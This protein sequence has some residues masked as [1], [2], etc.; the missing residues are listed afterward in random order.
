MDNLLRAKPSSKVES[1][2]TFSA[3]VSGL[4]S[5]FLTTCMV[6]E[7]LLVSKPD[8]CQEGFRKCASYKLTPKRSSMAA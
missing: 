6:Q 5:L 7:A 2:P 3:R 4:F 1:K 8:T